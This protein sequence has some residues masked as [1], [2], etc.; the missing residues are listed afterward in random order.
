MK[1][2]REDEKAT[3]GYDIKAQTW[4]NINEIKQ[5]KGYMDGKILRQIYNSMK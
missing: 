2:E 4:G 5:N 3:W 1:E